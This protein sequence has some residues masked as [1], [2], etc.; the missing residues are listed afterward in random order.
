MPVHEFAGPADKALW[1]APISSLGL[2]IAGTR[3]EPVVNEFL[4]ELQR[5]GVKRLRPHFY[6]SNEWGVPF[7]TTAIAIPFYLAR[8]DLT[9][10]HGEHA[11]H[12]E[13]S[14]PAD[15]LRYLRHEMGHVVNYAYKLYE[16]EDWVEHFGAIT[17]PYLEEYRPEPFSRRYVRHLPGWYAQKHPEEA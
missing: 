16:R 6:L 3:L 12:V 1:S 9:A 13:G 15:I 2:R 17:Q 8:P 7:D 11:G 10:L 4:G 5:A 14:S